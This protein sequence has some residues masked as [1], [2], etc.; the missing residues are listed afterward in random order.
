MRRLEMK[1]SGWKRKVLAQPKGDQKGLPQLLLF[2]MC[3]S[4]VHSPS[5]NQF[6]ARLFFLMNFGIWWRSWR[7]RT[8][9]TSSGP[10]QYQKCFISG[11]WPSAFEHLRAGRALSFLC[12]VPLLIF[13]WLSLNP[14][15]M[16]ICTSFM[17][18]LQHVVAMG[19]LNANA[20]ELVTL[21]TRI[22]LGFGG[23]PFLTPQKDGTETRVLQSF[24]ELGLFNHFPRTIMPSLVFYFFSPF[25][26]T[27]LHYCHR[28]NCWLN[29][30]MET[31][32]LKLLS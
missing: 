5:R 1:Q 8:A 20:L 29:F 16:S 28:G 6:S 9:L 10:A 27:V 12:P 17:S 22:D 15:I 31:R 21:S 18:H 19:G 3:H 30:A 25:S 24:I 4:Q 11:C 32:L 2:A 13:V 14:W 7:F 26:I 23:N